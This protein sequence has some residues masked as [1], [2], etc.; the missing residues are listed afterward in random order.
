MADRRGILKALG[1]GFLFAAVSVGVSHLV[2]STRAG[3]GYG[4]TLGIVIVLAMALKYPLFEFGQRYAAATGTSL[5]E[6]YRK[7]GK[8]TLVVYMILTIGTMFTVLAAVTAVTAG[9]AFQLT[10]L[11]LSTPL[12]SALLIAACAVLI[13]VGRYPLLDKAIKLIM[14]LLTVSTVAAVIAALPKFSGVDLWG[15]VDLT[16][17]A[18]MGFIVGL[19]GWMPTGMDVAAWQ[20]FWALA[21][22]RQTGYT[23]SLRETLFD[24]RLG[25]IGTGVLALLFLCL[26]TAVMFVEGVT[27]QKKAVD[28]AGQLIDLYTNTLGAWSRPVIGIAA[29]TTMFS[30]TLTVIDGFP[31]ALHLTCRRFFGPETQKEVAA[32]A[33]R[34]LGFWAWAGILIAGGMGIILFFMKDLLSLVNLAT[35]L[36]YVTGPFLGILAYRA[37]TAADVPEAYRPGRALR[38]HAIVGIVFLVGFFL[39]YLSTMDWSAS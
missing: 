28:F 9:L 12:W 30:T 29:F 10:G 34:T 21:R 39:F 16:S 4:L 11:D 26:G 25:Y 20:S 2:Q 3:A 22:R 15:P 31:R 8:W 37:M 33:V 1:P 7:Q 6:G 13:A 24:F 5:L 19:V 14:A 36:S 17:V 38:I 35:I 32:S 23:P 27:P 18:A